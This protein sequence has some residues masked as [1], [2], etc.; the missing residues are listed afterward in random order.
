MER[1]S[2]RAL[3]TA[4]RVRQIAMAEKGL[5]RVAVGIRVVSGLLA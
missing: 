1:S 5:V 3:P 2:P 4:A